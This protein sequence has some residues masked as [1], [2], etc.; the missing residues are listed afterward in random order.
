[1]EKF[2]NGELYLCYARPHPGERTIAGLKKM[3]GKRLVYSLS[4]LDVSYVEI[5]ISAK[6]KPFIKRQ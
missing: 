3:E 6:F 2:E 4:E 5:R 1:M